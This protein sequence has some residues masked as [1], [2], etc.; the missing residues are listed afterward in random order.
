M[1]ADDLDKL[2]R[3]PDCEAEYIQWAKGIR[4]QYGGLEQYIA[5]ERLGWDTK[6]LPL[7][8]G[9]AQPSHYFNDEVMDDLS[10]VKVVFNDWPYGIPLDC[11]H[12]VVW[13]KFPIISPALFTT[14]DT[15]FVAGAVRDVLFK[16]IMADGIRGLTGNTKRYPVI[17]YKAPQVMREALERHLDASKAPITSPLGSTGLGPEAD[18][19]EA[20][21]L[22]AGRFVDKFICRYWD[23]TVFE[24]AYFCNPPHLRTVP[25]LSHFHV[26][27]RTKAADQ[28]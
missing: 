28:R 17:G 13:C 12:Y 4:A 10:N 8:E 20:A 9:T 26:I 23:P 14:P 11:K 6:K 25:G 16:G 2:L 21:H 19:A 7:I 1:T 27:A 3:H 22:W 15:P 24:T 5:K 18:L